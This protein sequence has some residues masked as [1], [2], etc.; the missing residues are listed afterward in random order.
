VCNNTTSAPADKMDDSLKVTS[1]LMGIATIRTATE[2]ATKIYSDVKDR[3]FIFRTWSW[4]AETGFMMVSVVVRP[5]ARTLNGPIKVADSVACTIVDVAQRK[6]PIISETPENIL[7][8]SCET[9]AKTSCAQL[10]MSG[11]DKLLFYR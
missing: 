10:A 8:T 2:H 6:F 9:I 7:K 3:N 11:A 1:K 5:L 4:T